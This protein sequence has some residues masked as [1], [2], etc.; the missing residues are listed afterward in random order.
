MSTV[1]VRLRRTIVIAATFVAAV[2][3]PVPASAHSP[4]GTEGV[5]GK[6]LQTNASDDQSID[7][8]PESQP[9]TVPY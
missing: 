1:T 7:A 9:I 3:F 8:G 6:A 4:G 5:N 2:A